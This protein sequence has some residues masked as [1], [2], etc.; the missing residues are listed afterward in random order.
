MGSVSSE[1]EKDMEVWPH[2]HRLSQ[3]DP[4][5]NPEGR[6]HSIERTGPRHVA[7]LLG[8]DIHS[9]IWSNIRRYFKETDPDMTLAFHNDDFLGFFNS[10]PHVFCFAGQ[11]MVGF[12]LVALFETTK[13]GYPPKKTDLQGHFRA[14]SWFWAHFFNHLRLDIAY[15]ATFGC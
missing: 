10:V 5:T 7:G 8:P 2:N 9:T 1:A 3:S 6:R 11:Q 12:P 13:K 14:G 15:F 4:P